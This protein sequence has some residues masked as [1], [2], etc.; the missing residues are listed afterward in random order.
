MKRMFLLLI[1]A[2]AIVLISCSSPMIQQTGS[3]ASQT[4]SL[5]VK[6]SGAQSRDVA[7]KSLSKSI[8]GVSDIVVKLNPRN[9]NYAPLQASAAWGNS[10]SFSNVKPGSW[11]I[12]VYLNDSSGNQLYY[13]ESSFIKSTPEQT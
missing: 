6:I 11:D 1:V 5:V 12:L 7:G 2:V 10:V 3:P 4:G 13:G 9:S 8:T